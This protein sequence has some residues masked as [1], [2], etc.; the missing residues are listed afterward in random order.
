M[1]RPLAARAASDSER[2]VEVE[3]K[4]WD[5]AVSADP[6]TMAHESPPAEANGLPA[7]SR[8]RVL[9]AGARASKDELMPLAACDCDNHTHCHV[10]T[11]VCVADEVDTDVDVEGCGIWG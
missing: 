9:N 4:Q 11:D 8:I 7:R 10:H 1:K 5:E 2:A 3:S 6:K